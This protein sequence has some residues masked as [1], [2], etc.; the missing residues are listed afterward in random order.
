MSVIKDKLNEFK[1]KANRK[2][3]SSGVPFYFSPLW[4]SDYVYRGTHNPAGP[5]RKIKRYTLAIF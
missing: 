5:F 2:R 4:A 1:Q 3:V